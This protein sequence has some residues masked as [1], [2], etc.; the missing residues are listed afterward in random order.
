MRKITKNNTKQLLKEIEKIEK[1]YKDR[2]EQFRIKR[3]EIERL[4]DI[5]IDDMADQFNK[6]MGLMS[7][8]LKD[9]RLKHLVE[10]IY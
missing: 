4:S 5:E 3:N 1:E 9:Y 10:D 6:V 7:I 2:L 8:Q